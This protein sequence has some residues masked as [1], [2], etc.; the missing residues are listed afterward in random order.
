MRLPSFFVV[1]QWLLS[2]LTQVNS[3]AAAL[4]SLQTK[5]VVEYALPAAGQTHEILAVSDRLLL[6]SQQTDGSLVKV[7]LDANGQPTGARRVGSG[8]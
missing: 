4:H 5:K 1:F 8:A 7:S 6:I 3:S 2:L